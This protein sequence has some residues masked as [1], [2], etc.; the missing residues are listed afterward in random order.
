MKQDDFDKYRQA[1]EQYY[2]PSSPTIDKD[3][4]GNLTLLNSAINREYKN[5]LFPQK[6]RTIK[7]SDQEGE[8][9]PPCTRYLFMKYYSNTKANLSSFNMQRWNEDDQEDYKNAI[10]YT[11]KKFLL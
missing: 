2:A 11:L 8:Y 7:R 9:I 1:V 5:A 6:L 3:W 4:I 10:I